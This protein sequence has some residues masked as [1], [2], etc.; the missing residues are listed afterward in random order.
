V[1]NQTGDMASG[2]GLWNGG[3]LK[4]GLRGDGIQKLQIG[5]RGWLAVH[6][7]WEVVQLE[8]V[9]VGGAWSQP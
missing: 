1:G 5:H 2:L 4:S 8:V 9:L 6:V 3:Q 7:L